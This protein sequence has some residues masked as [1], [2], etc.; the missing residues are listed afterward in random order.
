VS[1]ALA[2]ER[3]FTDEYKKMPFKIEWHFY[4]NQLID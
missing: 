1:N 2:N 3:C 4:L